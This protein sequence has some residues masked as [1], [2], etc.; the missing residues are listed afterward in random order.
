VAKEPEKSSQP[1]RDFRQTEAAVVKEKKFPV[2][3]HDELR[4]HISQSAY[5][6]MKKHAATTDEVELCGVLVGQ[7]GRDESGY[8]LTITGSIEGEG[9]KNL[10]SQ[11]T[12]T[13]DTWTHIHEVKDRDYPD[14]R[15][16]GWY[17]THPGFGVFLSSM[18]TFINENF[19]SES[20]QVAVVLETVRKAEG[21]FAWINGKCTALRRYWVGDSEVALTQGDPESPGD[22]PDDGK[23]SSKEKSKEK[24]GGGKG[25]S[26][27]DHGG[28][29]LPSFFSVLFMVLGF[30]AGIFVGWYLVSGKIDEIS[31]QT[32]ESETYGIIEEAGLSATAALDMKDIGDRIKAVR[33]GMA[34]DKPADT[35]AK[36]DAVQKDIATMQATYMRRPSQLRRQLDTLSNMRVG[37]SRRVD[38]SIASQQ[39]LMASVVDL[40]LLRLTELIGGPGKVDPSAY[41]PDKQ[42]AV[43]V[44]LFRVIA[45]MPESKPAIRNMFP[46]LIEFYYPA[47]DAPKPVIPDTPAPPKSAPPTTNTLGFPSVPGK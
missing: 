39:V 41:S 7:V 35:Q 18:D 26:F 10:G 9:A 31:R 3:V 34:T 27:D 12:F 42:E 14:T 11:V 25:E 15:I 13:H 40:Y 47:S 43:G 44:I 6:K 2:S 33:E 37:L 1:K 46:G 45:M 16:V 29:W 28:G 24:S 30:A 23:S 8:F 4:V 5:D 19:F 17:H 32:V 22:A 21:C 36:L 38:A 20:Y